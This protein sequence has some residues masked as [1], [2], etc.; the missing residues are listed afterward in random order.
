MAGASVTL[1]AT[2]GDLAVPFAGYLSGN[3]TLTGAVDTSGA[4]I[5]ASGS[6]NLT[7]NGRTLGPVSFSLSI[8]GSLSW[9]DL[10]DSITQIA[11]F[12]Q[13]AGVSPGQIA[14]YLEDFG[15][16]LYDTINALADI[17]DWGPA[18]VDG[19]ASVFGFS[20]TYYDIWTYTFPGV[21]LVLDVQG[22]SQAPNTDVITWL[23]NGGYNQDWEFVQSPYTGYYEIMNRGSGQCLSVGNDSTGE[24]QDLVQYPCFGASDQL[25]YL[26][27]IAQGPHYTIWSALDSQVVDVQNADPYAGGHVDQWPSNGGS[28]QSFWLTSSTN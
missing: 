7:A 19:L 6:A 2:S 14:Q 8:P 26:G 25:W 4:K 15:Y 1:S 11:S 24:G 13:N 21:P 9:S 27:N 18:V 16:S 10:A 23:W 22:G 5:S 28:N 17:G 12:F 20:T 3:L